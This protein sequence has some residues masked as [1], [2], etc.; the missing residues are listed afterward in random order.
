[1]SY[2]EQN[3]T[4]GDII[5]SAKLNHIEEGV[6]GINMSYE[7]TTWQLGDTITAEKLNNIEDGIASGGSSDFSI[8]EVTVIGDAGATDFYQPVFAYLEN[9]SLVIP[10]STQ[11][12]NS[13]TYIVPLYKGSSMGYTYDTI[14]ATS[15]SISVDGYDFTITG[16]CSITIRPTE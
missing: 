9:D 15:G 10:T 4:T 6:E 3:W 13:H 5:T 8:A 7:K 2:V 1:M 14:V 16:N 12:D 11:E